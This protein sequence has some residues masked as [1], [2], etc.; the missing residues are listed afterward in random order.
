MVADFLRLLIGLSTGSV[1]VIATLIR[2]IFPN[3]SALWTL[4]VSLGLFAISVACSIGYL[5][6]LGG[7]VSL[8]ETL[9][10]LQPHRYVA[11]FGWLWRGALAC[12]FLGFSLLSFFILYNLP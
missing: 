8:K 5:L 12:F 10:E 11:R 6:F 9:P 1:L 2:D 7:S 4:R 3:P